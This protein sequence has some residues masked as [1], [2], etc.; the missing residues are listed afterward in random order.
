MC[1]LEETDELSCQGPTKF[2][3]ERSGTSE[4]GGEEC[5]AR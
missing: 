2:D 1:V 3:L 4:N 5:E